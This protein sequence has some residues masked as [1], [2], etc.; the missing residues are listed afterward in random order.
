M[1]ELGLLKELKQFHK[2][3]N[4]RRLRENRYDKQT[5][6]QSYNIR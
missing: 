2:D 6:K 3:Y 5:N 1:L 4:D